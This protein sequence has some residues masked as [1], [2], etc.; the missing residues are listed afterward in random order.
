MAAASSSAPDVSERIQKVQSESADNS[1]FSTRLPYNAVSVCVD[2]SATGE[3]G[4]G[5]SFSLVHCRRLRRRQ[6]DAICALCTGI[7]SHIQV[8]RRIEPCR[9]YQGARSIQSAPQALRQGT[10][11]RQHANAALHG[12]TLSAY[13]HKALTAQHAKSHGPLKAFALPSAGWFEASNDPAIMTQ[14]L[15]LVQTFMQAVLTE[16]HCGENGTP[17]LQIIKGV[18]EDA[19]KAQ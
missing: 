17:A 9:D 7:P 10:R 16:A 19:I 12:P 5:V 18:S 6:S 11:A 15:P 4:H 13:H 2:N 14:R 8:H 1:K 3:K